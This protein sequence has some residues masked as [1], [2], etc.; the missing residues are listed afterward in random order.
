VSDDLPN[1][2]DEGELFCPQCGYDLRGLGSGRCPE[3]GLAIDAPTAGAASRIPWV[4]G[5]RIGRWR[6]FWRTAWEAT[7]RPSRLAADVAKPV[8]LR[9]ALAFRRAVVWVVWI[10][11]ALA[12]AIGY[13]SVLADYSLASAAF[14]WPAALFEVGGVAV[15][16]AAAWLWLLLGCGVASY[17]FHPR[18]LPVER[19]NRAVAVSY[20]ACGPLAWV[21]LAGVGAVAVMSLSVMGVA[22]GP[23]IDAP[24]I[25]TIA[26]FGGAVAALLHTSVIFVGRATQRGLGRKAV[27]AVGLPLAW[28]GLLLLVVGGILG[29]YL[30][31]ATVVLTLRG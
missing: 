5:A 3:C 28:A 12:S 18:R 21:S 2:A 4:H 22:G 6:A 13:A 27:V 26:M 7:V 1:P 16:L 11:I 14:D 20:Y 25:A 23:L 8:E 29:T 10:P 31:V 19:Q 24:L 30:L 15:A 9:D 17:L